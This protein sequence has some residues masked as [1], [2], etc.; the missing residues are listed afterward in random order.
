LYL[1][2]ADGDGPAGGRE[3]QHATDDKAHGRAKSSAVDQ[4]S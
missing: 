1:Q 2:Q 4:T 3:K